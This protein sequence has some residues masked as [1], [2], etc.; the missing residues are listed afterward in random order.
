ME[1]PVEIQMEYN[2]ENGSLE[3]DFAGEDMGILIG[4]RR[5]DA[6]FPSVSDQPCSQ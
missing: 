5:T 4:K 2:A 1:L 3:V 6:G